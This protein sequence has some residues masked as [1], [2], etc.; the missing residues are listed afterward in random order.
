VINYEN[1]NYLWKIVR[2]GDRHLFPIQ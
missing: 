2:K 1:D